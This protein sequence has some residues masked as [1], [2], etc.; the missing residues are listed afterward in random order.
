MTTPPTNIL[1]QSCRSTS[2][3]PRQQP[4][5]QLINCTALHCTTRI[6]QPKPQPRDRHTLAIDSRTR[7][8]ACAPLSPRVFLPASLL[9]VVAVV[10]EGCR[11]RRL[12]H[13]SEISRGCVACPPALPWN[14]RLTLAWTVEWS[15]RSPIA[16]LAQGGFSGARAKGVPRFM[17]GLECCG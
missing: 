4:A 9:C 7:R 2:T 12:R 8:N 6:R 10:A 16:G 14:W 11:R 1:A 13:A 3:H 5:S 17:M 15:G